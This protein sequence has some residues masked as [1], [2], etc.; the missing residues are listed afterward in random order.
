MVKRF[1]GVFLCAFFLPTGL[2]V[3]DEGDKVRDYL[4]GTCGLAG[5][6]KGSAGHEDCMAEERASFEE[7]LSAMRT[8]FEEACTEHEAGS[9]S[10]QTCLRQEGDEL[11][12][13]FRERVDAIEEDSMARELP[14]FHE[15]LANLCSSVL[16]QAPGS[17]SHDYCIAQHAI[18]YSYFAQAVLQKLAEDPT[19]DSY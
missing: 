4:E 14:D 9:D 5:D 19:L 6:G 8:D 15:R 1:A 7:N 17:P 3:A 11:A 2:A 13:H 12:A 16:R 10:R 18:Q